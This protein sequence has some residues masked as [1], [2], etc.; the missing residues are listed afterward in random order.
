MRKVK[1]H[2]VKFYHKHVRRKFIDLI[3]ELLEKI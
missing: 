2:S 3:A 1:L